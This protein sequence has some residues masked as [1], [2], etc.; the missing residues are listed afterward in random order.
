MKDG[1]EIG[2]L[3]ERRAFAPN[4]MKGGENGSRGKNILYY[5]DG[6]V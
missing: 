2:M 3:S 4:G 6:R 1:I 5:P